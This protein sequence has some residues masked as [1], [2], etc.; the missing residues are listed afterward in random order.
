MPVTNE[1]QARRLSYIALRCA[2]LACMAIFLYRRAPPIQLI[3]NSR[4]RGLATLHAHGEGNPLDGRTLQGRARLSR[5][6]RVLSAVWSFNAW[7]SR[8]N[9]NDDLHP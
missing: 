7:E 5:A 6:L 3:A 1:R 4:T 8:S 2:N 9:E